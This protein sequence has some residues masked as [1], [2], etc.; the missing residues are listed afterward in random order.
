M[1]PSLPKRCLTPFWSSSPSGEGELAPAFAS[2][3]ALTAETSITNALPEVSS[4]KEQ[5]MTFAVSGPSL[6]SAAIDDYFIGYEDEEERVDD[7]D[8]QLFSGD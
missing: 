3:T 5:A 8:L 4:V 7:S 1:L 2:S 6:N